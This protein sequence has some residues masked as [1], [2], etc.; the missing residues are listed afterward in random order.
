MSSLDEF[1]RKLERMTLKNIPGAEKLM[2]IF[3]KKCEDISFRRDSTMANM[4][5][6]ISRNDTNLVNTSKEGLI[7]LY[8]EQLDLTLEVQREFFNLKS[9]AKTKTEP[10][11]KVH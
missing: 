6:G 2:D 11:E 4:K 8:R 5:L 1:M 9:Q 7:D 10:N 3:D